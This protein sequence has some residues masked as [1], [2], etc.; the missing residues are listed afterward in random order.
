VAVGTLSSISSRRK[1]KSCRS[2][3]EGTRPEDVLSAVP[4]VRHR[5][6][7]TQRERERARERLDTLR[8]FA[9]NRSQ[10]IPWRRTRVRAPNYQI[11]V[12]LLGTLHRS[13]RKRPIAS[14]FVNNTTS[15]YALRII[16]KAIGAAIKKR[17]EKG[18]RFLIG[19]NFRLS[20]RRTL[21]NVKDFYM[22]CLC[23]GMFSMQTSIDQVAIF[24]FEKRKK[25]RYRSAV[26]KRRKT[27]SLLSLAGRRW[28][29]ISYLVRASIQILCNC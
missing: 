10:R 14:F 21:R 4:I 27:A 8:E 24:A 1:A 12:K 5:R 26:T 3:S 15:H 22:R 17:K 20:H 23:F 25:N 16:E 9:R 11:G 29:H 13:M 18:M 28:S 6:R 19:I 2:K 7:E